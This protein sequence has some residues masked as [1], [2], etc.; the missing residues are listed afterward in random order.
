[1]APFCLGRKMEPVDL[2]ERCYPGRRAESKRHILRCALALF[3][4]QGIEATTIDIIRAE[5]QMSVG[6][7]YHH[8]D[9]KEG[10]VAALYMTALDDQARLRDSYLGAVTSTREWVHALV[11][12]YVDWVVSQPDWARFQYQARFA[13]ARS[14]FNERL[15]EANVA[16]N[17]ALKQW[18]S[19]PAH[20]QDLQDL[21]FELIPSLIIGSAESYCRAWLSARVKRSPE[22]YR[23]QLAEAAWRAVGAG[24]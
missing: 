4:Q 20:Q 6:A 15:A 22:L 17:A 8:F 11:F 18:F 23:Q 12:S 7:I 10:L 21:P 3:N 1:M 16:R 9:N 14:S 19:D 5:S 2:L 24:G 13:V